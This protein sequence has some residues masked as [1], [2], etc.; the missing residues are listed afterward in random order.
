M[1][2]TFSITLDDDEIAAF[3]ENYGYQEQV[4]NRDSATRQQRATIPNPVSREEFAKR[5]IEEHIDQIV[6]DYV[7]TNAVQNVREQA[8]ADLRRRKPRRGR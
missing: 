6:E 5:K 4:P 2:I 8:I 1:P 3:V 7:G